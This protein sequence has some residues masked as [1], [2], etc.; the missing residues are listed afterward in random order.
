[1]LISLDVI[2]NMGMAAKPNYNPG[3]QDVDGQKWPVQAIFRP[4]SFFVSFTFR[5][6][7]T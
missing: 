7:K 2:P 6:Q 1:M 3:W 5:P 4:Q